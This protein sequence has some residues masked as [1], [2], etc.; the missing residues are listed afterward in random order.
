M[1]NTNAG[2]GAINTREIILDMLCEICEK[3]SYS[4]IV[5]RQTLRKYQYLDKRDRAFITRI[6]EGT[7]ENRI[8]LDYIIDKFSNV[9]V[10]K[11]KPLIRNLLRMSVYQIMFMDSVPVSA[12]CNEAVKLAIKRSFGQLRG[13]VNGVLR[14][15]IR[16]K[17]EIKYPN[18]SE[19]LVEYLNVV[20][21]MPSWIV[22]QLIVQY[23]AEEASR[24]IK[25]MSTHSEA[26][27]VRANTTDSTIEDII[28]MLE[29]DDIKVTRS[30]I[31]DKALYLENID[32]LENTEAFNEGLISVQ[33]LSSMLVA[34]IAN[35]KSGDLCMDLCAAPG[36]KALHLW[37]MMKGEGKV[38]ARDI[39]DYKVGLIE[40][41]IDRTQS[42]GVEAQV[43]DATELDE[44]YI[45]KADVVVADLPCSG[46][47]IIGKKSDIKYNETRENQKDLVKLQREI[48]K[49]AW[50]Y[51]KV[52][53]TLVYS[54]CTL[55]KEENIENVKFIEEN[56]PLKLVDISTYVP[57][58]FCGGTARKGYIQMLPGINGTDGFFIS[59]FE[60]Y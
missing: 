12:T 51:V 23:G 7:L 49:N 32:Y 1:I 20:Y 44:E 14:A 41:N 40:E 26:I 19:N 33:D 45:G 18:A 36:G 8:L 2:A 5:L 16:N 15:V 9:K 21:S 10:K 57:E 39:S 28:K 4:H 35:P 52:G 29:E 54:T 53:G 47:G 42:M 6:T 34:V 58:G 60:R 43:Y 25:A 3:G 48:L 56:Y 17:D 13:F 55:N 27:C 46:L 37:E 30:D 22:E 59:R 11:M 50:Q 24:I 31:Y 38:I